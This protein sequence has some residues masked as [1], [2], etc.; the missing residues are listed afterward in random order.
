M[1]RGVVSQ[2]LP[3]KFPAGKDL[4]TEEAISGFEEARVFQFLGGVFEAGNL[5]HDG[6]ICIV[7]LPTFSG[8]RTSTWY[9]TGDCH[10]GQCGCQGIVCLHPYGV[11]RQGIFPILGGSSQDS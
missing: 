4:L 11:D 6:S 1:F 5:S 8:T 3:P 9:P 2:P 7:Y 10:K